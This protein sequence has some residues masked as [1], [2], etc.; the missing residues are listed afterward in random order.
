M[1]SRLQHK[2]LA[3]AGMSACLLAC[4]IWRASYEAGLVGAL[5]VIK[6][7]GPPAGIAA[8]LLG[9][10]LMYRLPKASHIPDFL[11]QANRR[12]V[13]LL[14]IVVDFL[15]LAVATLGIRFLIAFSYQ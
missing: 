5:G 4:A 3:L 13:T 9:I 12:V 7:L 8:M 11:L 14:V 15:L 1:S 2:R 10:E 6:L